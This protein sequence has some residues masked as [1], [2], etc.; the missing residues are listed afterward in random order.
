MAQQRPPFET[1]EG[2][3]CKGSY[4]LGSAC[5]NCERCAW[6][7]AQMN[8][9]GNG[10]PTNAAA[11][12]AKPTKIILTLA[13]NAFR[14]D[15][16]KF[17][18]E[19]FDAIGKFLDGSTTGAVMVSIERPPAV[20]VTSFMEEIRGAVARGWCHPKN[21]AKEFDSDLAEAISREVFDLLAAWRSA[22]GYE[23]RLGC[24]TTLQL[25]AELQVR[26]E[27]SAVTGEKWPNYR[28]IDS[29]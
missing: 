14:T 23:P 20:D 19:I 7:R 12:P 8:V 2:A 24:A 22:D 18:N 27:V 28:T 5:G 10:V 13:A 16:F 9:A 17:M 3:T 11:A 1:F 25:I 21:S 15:P 6:E 26:A 4:L 29:R